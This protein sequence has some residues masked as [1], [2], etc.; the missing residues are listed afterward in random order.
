MYSSFQ[1]SVLSSPSGVLVDTIVMM[2]AN[3]HPMTDI[4]K[5][6]SDSPPRMVN[7]AGLPDH[8][9]L[10]IAQ[11]AVAPDSRKEVASQLRVLTVL[12]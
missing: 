4:E 6:F 3:R 11:Q 9:V 10:L 12:N 2:S 5:H 8:L 7:I 1:V